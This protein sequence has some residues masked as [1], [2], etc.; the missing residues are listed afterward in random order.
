VAVTPRW[1]CPPC[2]EQSGGDL[3]KAVALNA[4]PEAQL[5]HTSSTVTGKAVKDGGEGLFV[6]CMIWSTGKVSIG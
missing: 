3:E 1:R 2:V 5:L 4:T 6:G